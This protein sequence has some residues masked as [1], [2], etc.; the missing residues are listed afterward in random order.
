[1]SAPEISTDAVLPSVA[2]VSPETIACDSTPAA[3]RPAETVNTK[4]SAL[5]WLPACACTV[6]LAVLAEVVGMSPSNR[7]V[8]AAST[9]AI[10]CWN[11]T[12]AP[13]PAL[14]AVVVEEAR[15]A[16]VART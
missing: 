3:L 12:A 1:M 8:V 6:R 13:S 2:K 10:V 4:V 5:A 16:E 11:A 15:F 14:T 7:A 9:R